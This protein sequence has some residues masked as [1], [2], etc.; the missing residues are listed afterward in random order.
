MIDNLVKELKIGGLPTVVIDGPE[1]FKS[2]ASEKIAE[3]LRDTQSGT[4]ESNRTRKP[5][6]DKV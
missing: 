2:K 4:H 1:W 6:Q 3:Q 5:A